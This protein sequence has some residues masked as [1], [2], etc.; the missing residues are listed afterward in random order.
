MSCSV[1]HEKDEGMRQLA[2]TG[3]QP[4]RFPLALK[5]ARLGKQLKQEA[6]AAQLHVKV[7]T[8]VSW[9]TGARLP[10]VGMVALLIDLLADSLDLSHD[11]LLAYIADDLARQIPLQ[12]DEQ[13]SLR[14][15]RLLGQVQ[16]KRDEHEQEQE[17]HLALFGNRSGER[18]QE[19]APVHL[20]VWQQEQPEISAGSDPLRQLFTVLETLREQPELIPVVQDFL[21][22]VTAPSKQ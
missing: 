2:P 12:E 10:S 1:P 9:E 6:L 14:A 11:L 15:F 13:L 8:L 16:A 18:H 21:R 4:L 5:Q 7:R 22:E 19:L 20:G 3:R 17:P